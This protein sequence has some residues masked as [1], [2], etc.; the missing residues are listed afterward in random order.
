[1][2]MAGRV[3]QRLNR[4]PSQQ[5]V[6][7]GYLL[8]NDGSN[9]ISRRII[10]IQNDPNGLSQRLQ[11]GVFG[12]GY[13]SGRPSVF[14]SYHTAAELWPDYASSRHRTCS[15]HRQSAFA[16]S[17]VEKPAR[18]PFKEVMSVVSRHYRLNLK[19]GKAIQMLGET[20]LSISEIAYKT[21]FESLFYFSRM[22][23]K[24]M[25]LAPSEF[26]TK[27]IAGKL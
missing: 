6:R 25:D 12:R 5:Q 27:R 15:A 11:R 24:K 3:Q 10:I 7:T 2:G 20:S 19:I 26:R 23:R 22:F 17:H 4:F 21:G 8:I 13:G 1:M 18:W 14:G 9:P 16:D